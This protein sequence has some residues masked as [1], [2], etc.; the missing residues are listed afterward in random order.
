M[1]L[2]CKYCCNLIEKDK[3]MRGGKKQNSCQKCQREHNKGRANL[4]NK[5]ISKSS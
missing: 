3:Q 2:L 5:T 1:L 4:R